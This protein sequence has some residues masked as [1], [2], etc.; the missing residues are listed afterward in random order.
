VILRE[1]YTLHPNAHAHKDMSVY[2][3]STCVNMPRV[4]AYMHIRICSSSKPNANAH[5]HT[6]THT[7]TQ[8]IH[9]RIHLRIYTR[10]RICTR[11]R[12]RT[13]MLVSK[14]SRSRG[15]YHDDKGPDK[16]RALALERVCACFNNAIGLTSLSRTGTQPYTRAERERER[17]RE[18]TPA[19]V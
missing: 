12:T 9:I 6:H 2:A 14:L 15:N 10:T 17:E 4:H 11:T 7:R 13:R 8:T 5:A 3:K 1:P 16:P 19:Q 18:R